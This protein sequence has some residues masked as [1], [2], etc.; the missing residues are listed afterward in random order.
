MRPSS[1][2]WSGASDRR[3]DRPQPYDVVA[4][5]RVVLPGGPCQVPS[6]PAVTFGDS[7]M[8]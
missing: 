8:A 5:H 4:V 2:S 3:R 6:V 1:R 7:F